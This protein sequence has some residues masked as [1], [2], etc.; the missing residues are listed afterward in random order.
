M[1]GIFVVKKQKYDTIID[2]NILRGARW[3]KKEQQQ[4]YIINFLI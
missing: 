1:I 2:I 3:K 4:D